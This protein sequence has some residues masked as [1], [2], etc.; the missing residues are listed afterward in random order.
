MVVWLFLAVTWVCLR[1]GI[2]V[3][4]DHNHLLFLT[5]AMRN[6]CFHV[7]NMKQLFQDVHIESSKTFLKEINLFN[8][9]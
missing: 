1:F 7:D 8:K 2:V 4:P 6:K 9:L 5:N 3:Y